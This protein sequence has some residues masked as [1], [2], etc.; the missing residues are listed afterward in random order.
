[1][2]NVNPNSP[3][4]SSF[5]VS[6]GDVIKIQRP[7]GYPPY[8]RSTE[9]SSGFAIPEEV[10]T[11]EEEAY[12]FKVLETSLGKLVRLDEV[13]WRDGFVYYEHERSGRQVIRYISHGIIDVTLYMI[14]QGI[15]VHDHASVYQGG[16]AYA[17]YWA[18]VPAEANEEGG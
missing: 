16:P 18:E 15:E 6:V 14:V 17:T 12:G 10:V 4:V 1:M 7:A 8:P 3:N 11:T 13:D 5:T 9:N 2:V